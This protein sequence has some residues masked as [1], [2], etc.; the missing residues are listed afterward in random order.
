MAQYPRRSESPVS[1][2]KVTQCQMMRVGTLNKKKNC[3][4]VEGTSCGISV[5]VLLH[6]GWM[7]EN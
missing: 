2:T 3:A 1:T 6:S 7:E 4:A 5:A